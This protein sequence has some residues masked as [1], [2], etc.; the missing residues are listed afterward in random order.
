MAFEKLRELLRLDNALTEAE[1]RKRHYEARAA[2]ITNRRHM[3]EGLRRRLIV[4]LE[5]DIYESESE[6]NDLRGR[7]AALR[8]VPA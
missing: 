6:I 7:L 4:R 2:E 8:E 1:A 3:D 5:Q